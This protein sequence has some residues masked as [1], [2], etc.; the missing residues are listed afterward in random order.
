VGASILLRV[1]MSREEPTAYTVH[2]SLYQICCSDA[3]FSC[4]LLLPLPYDYLQEAETSRKDNSLS[5][6]GHGILHILWNLKFR[7]SVRKCP[8]LV[9]ILS[10]HNVFHIF[11]HNKFKIY[12]NIVLPSMP[13]SYKCSLPFRFPNQS[14]GY[15]LLLLHVPSVISLISSA[16]EY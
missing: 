15:I 12:F 10:R 6:R 4:V 5:V 2:R 16:K 11:P 1:S 7:C 8:P 9:Y 13:S 14:L 3:L